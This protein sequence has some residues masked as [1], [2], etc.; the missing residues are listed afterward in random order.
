M[1]NRFIIITTCYNVSPYIEHNITVNKFQSHDNALFVYVDDQSK[2]GTYNT[3]KNLTENNE[4]FLVIKNPNNGSQS[5]AYLYALKY[6]EKNNLI[7]PEDI[8]VEIDGDDWLSSTFVLEYLNGIYQNDNIWMTYGQYQMWPNG[9][10]GGHYYMEI[11]KE[12]DKLNHHR[13]HPFPYSHLKTYKYWLLNN[14]D[15]KDLIDPKTNELYSEAWDHVL[16]LPMVEMAG[17]DHIHKCED[18]LYILNRHEDLQ[19]EG[20]F[21]PNA[22]K[23]AESR[24]RQ[25]KI[26][27]KFNRPQITCDLLGPSNGNYGLANMMFQIA[28]LSSLA[29]DNNGVATFPQLK[30]PKYGEY[31]SN[32]LNKV[33]V[34]GLKGLFK[35]EKETPFEYQK[36]DFIPNTI[37]KGYFQSEKYFA[38]NRDFIINLFKNKNILKE[39]KSKY[40]NITD[41]SISLHVRRGDYIN[42]QTYHPL[43]TKEYYDKAISKIGSYKNIFIFSDD[44]PWCKK[45]LNYKNTIF[46]EN[47]TDF[48]DILAMSLCSNNIMANSSFSWWGAWLNENQNKT[49]IFPKKWFGAKRNL[50]DKDMIPSNGIAI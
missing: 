23:E 1:N 38:H 40:P 2:D 32:I 12:V 7:F 10:L 41:Q 15:K 22:Q 9:E 39:I 44:I 48:F 42:L 35:P 27:D 25:G 18:V 47:N 28:S 30:N 17:I 49:V 21:R 50:S 19:N 4:R 43:Q 5:K 26:Y 45:N 20:R 6:L 29:K 31:T 37:Y 24:C 33:P 16:C 34:G 36:L 13:T 14:V 8:I 3:L 11:D 46:M